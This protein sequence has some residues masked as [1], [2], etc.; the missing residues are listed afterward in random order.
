[1]GEGLRRSIRIGLATSMP[2][3]IYMAVAL[4]WSGGW[5]LYRVLLAVF[6]YIAAQ[7]LIIDYFRDKEK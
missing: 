3:S 7:T 6:C 4:T 5:P 1:M 2:M